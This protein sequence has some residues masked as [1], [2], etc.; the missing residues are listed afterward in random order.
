MGIGEKESVLE[1]RMTQIAI[2]EALDGAGVAVK[3]ADHLLD[4]YGRLFEAAQLD[5]SSRSLHDNGQLDNPRP[6]DQIPQT[7]SPGS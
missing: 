2:E 6:P 1:V 3:M 5:H 7:G 4:I